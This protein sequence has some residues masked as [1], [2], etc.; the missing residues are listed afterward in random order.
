MARGRRRGQPVGLG[1]LVGGWVRR[2]RYAGQLLESTLA[3]R[4]EQL[5]GPKLAARTQPVRIVDGVLTLRVASSAWLNELTFL[6]EQLRAQINDR[7]V[8]EPGSPARLR[9]LRFVVGPLGDRPTP[10]VRRERSPQAPP[11]EV[12]PATWQRAL[13]AAEGELG[14]LVEGDLGLA[15][16]RA[17]AA[18][19]ARAERDGGD[20]LGR[21]SDDAGE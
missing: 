4:W 3:L 19:L 6:R 14:G 8:G 1:S 12:S 5:V 11:P 13:R 17:R 20:V 2:N 18:Q 15:I 10:L 16:R 9:G 21:R 7:V